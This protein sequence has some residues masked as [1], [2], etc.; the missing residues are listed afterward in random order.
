[1][2]PASAS[3]TAEASV[4]ILAVAGHLAALQLVA[5]V[6]CWLAA[7][8]PA[9]ATALA[10]GW[11]LALAWDIR[12]ERLAGCLPRPLLAL[13]LALAEAPALLFGGWNILHFLGHAPR[14]EL[15]A[16]VIQLWLTPLAPLVAC[17][18]Q[19]SWL[20][21]D[22]W[23]W[24]LSAAP[25]LLI[26]GGVLIARVRPAGPADGGAPLGSAEPGARGAGG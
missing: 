7:P 4:R 23:L 9:L 25:C 11:L 10:L 20:G 3:S 24:L 5:G 1:M 15:G 22:W 17:C 26:A 21:R 8:R 12:H 14:F 6:A 19:G 2:D 16:V 13:A 18:P